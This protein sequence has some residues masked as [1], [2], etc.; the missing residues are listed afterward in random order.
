V[1]MLESR[2]GTPR[3]L[4]LWI[5]GVGG[6]LV[7]LSGRVTLGQAVGDAPV[8]V[9]LLADVSRMHATLSRDPEGYIIE[10]A[11]PVLVNGKSQ[12]RAL[13]QPNDRVTLG[14]S[15]QFLFQKPVPVSGSAR[16]EMASGHRLPLSVSA[17]LLMADSLVLGPGE[18]VHVSMPDRKDNIVLYRQNDGLGIRCPGNFQVDG[19]RCKDKGML[20]LQA[21][22][23]GPDFALAIEPAGRI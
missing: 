20:G 23:Q 8:D 2:A 19:K 16:L 13:L 10:A 15:C 5:D 12:T 1:S 4:L 11:R 18:Q 17:V 14:T 7:C 6:Y 22:A 9:P 21:A 3:R